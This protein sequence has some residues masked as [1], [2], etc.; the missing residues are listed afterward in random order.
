MIPPAPPPEASPALERFLKSMKIGFHEWHDGIG[1]DLAALQEMTPAEAT[2]VEELILSYKGRDWRDVETLA[3]LNTPASIQ[4][5]KDCLHNSNL[6]ARLCAVRL[7]KEMEI[8]DRI[9][10]VVVE[11]LPLTTIGAGLSY[12]LNLAQTYPSEAIRRKVLW[13]ALNG[14]KDIRIHCAAMSLYLYGVTSVTFDNRYPVIYEFREPLRVM[15][16]KPFRQLCALVGV[17]PASLE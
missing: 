16:L 12:A 5:M 2:Y 13:C 15:R 1:Y 10:K 11:T 8:E 14:S 7:L 6:D 9:E 4:A 3:A 17:D